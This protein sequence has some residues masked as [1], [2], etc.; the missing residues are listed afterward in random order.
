MLCRRCE[1]P[2]TSFTGEI[3]IHFAGLTGLNKPVVWLFPEVK[4]CLKCGTAEFV[5]PE[6]ERKVLADRKPVEGA[7]I[8]E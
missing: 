4:I 6:R 5:V 8:S 1:S 7:M 3:A 2:R